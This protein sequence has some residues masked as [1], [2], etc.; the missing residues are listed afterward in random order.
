MSIC[1]IGV[2]F[3]MTMLMVMPSQ[4][5]IVSS[6][7]SHYVLRHEAKS[8]LD[9]EA[10]WER[11]IEPSLWWHPEHT[12]SGDSKNLSLEPKAGGLWRE[13]WNENSVEH[14]RVINVATGKMIRL[15]APFGPLQ[16]M[17]VTT[18]W[19]ITIKADGDHSII[20]FDEIANGSSLS[21]LDE[22]AKAVDFV[23]SEAIVRLSKN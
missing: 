7:A 10:L 5:E 16:E 8:E 19:T 11:L 6:S 12:Y 2:L 1:K 9:I 14:G 15:D 23:K 13:D 18:I 22:L 21:G 20:V 4:A 3:I 17:A